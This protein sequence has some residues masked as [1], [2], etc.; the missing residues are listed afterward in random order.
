MR[1]VL[2]ARAQVQRAGSA[3][4][5][6]ELV[7]HRRPDPGRGPVPQSSPTRVPGDALGET[8]AVDLADPG[9]ERKQDPDQSGSVIDRPARR[10]FVAAGAWWQPRLDLLP[11]QVR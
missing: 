5:G 7:V 2:R 11:Q 10:V 9:P 6:Q 8:D 1:A 4:L 3:R